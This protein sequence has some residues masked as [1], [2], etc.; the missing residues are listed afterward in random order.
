VF[1]IRSDV[2]LSTNNILP[3]VP[4]NILPD[5]PLKSL[6]YAQT[7]LEENNEELI[8]QNQN[9]VAAAVRD[10][11]KKMSEIIQASV[12][13]AVF[14]DSNNFSISV[15]KKVQDRAAAGMM[16]DFS[17]EDY[18]R[19]YAGYVAAKVKGGIKNPTGSFLKDLD[20]GKYDDEWKEALE[21]NKELPPP[22]TK[23]E[24]LREELE[25]YEF[26]SKLAKKTLEELEAKQQTDSA[27]ALVRITKHGIE[28]M[29]RRS[30][31]IIK[32]LREIEKEGL[33]EES[34]KAI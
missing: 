7:Y 1:N 26:Q 24:L 18:L 31:E 3:D 15:G 14:V 30:K 25:E 13:E 19:F 20:G 21:L 8:K 17:T 23:E 12:P 10:I 29:K 11:L 28:D 2:P 22:P 4:D 5:V 9:I 34:E 27:A 32:E 16:S 33:E 6:T